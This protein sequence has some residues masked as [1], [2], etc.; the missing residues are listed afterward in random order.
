MNLRYRRHSL[1]RSGIAVAFIAS[2]VQW[3]TAAGD[4]PRRTAVTIS[5]VRNSYRRIARGPQTNPDGTIRVVTGRFEIRL[6]E[7][8]TG[9]PIGKPL[10]PPG[11]GEVT[12]W[13]FSSDGKLFAAG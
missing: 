10:R 8:A 5:V 11:H 4:E 7:V 3:A 2:S 1:T 12:T 13:S 9:K 6:I